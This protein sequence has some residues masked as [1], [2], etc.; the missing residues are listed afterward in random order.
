MN[1]ALRPGRRNIISSTCAVVVLAMLMVAAGAAETSVYARW[2]NGP[3]HDPSFFP[4]AVWMQRPANAKA[5]QKAGINTYVGLWDGPTEA[6][7]AQ[8]KSSGMKLVCRQN[9]VAQKPC[10]PSQ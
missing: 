7:L 6:Q 9:E 4:I 10:G 3:P 1:A 2:K 5:F 8:L